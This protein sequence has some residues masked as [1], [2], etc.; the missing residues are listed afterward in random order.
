MFDMSNMGEMAEKVN[1]NVGEYALVHAKHGM[2]GGLA[3]AMPSFIVFASTVLEAAK[4]MDIEFLEL[5]VESMNIHL[6]EAG[7]E[8][9]LVTKEE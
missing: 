1:K 9:I 2:E 5:V 7:I 3:V 8:L 6:K 4:T